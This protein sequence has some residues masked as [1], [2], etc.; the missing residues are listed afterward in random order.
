MT[1]GVKLIWRGTPTCRSLCTRSPSGP[2]WYL[3]G[4]EVPV[5]T[6]P[7]AYEKQLIDEG[8]IE[9]VA[10]VAPPAPRVAP[11]LVAPHPAA[12]VPALPKPVEPA[13]LPRTVKITVDSD[14]SKELE[15]LAAPV[16]QAPEPRPVARNPEADKVPETAPVRARAKAKDDDGRHRSKKGKKR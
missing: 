5:G 8:K 7:P 10:P 3:P 15:R 14:L 4:E 6:L 13:P 1:N 12:S 16:P 2:K 11:L 9:R